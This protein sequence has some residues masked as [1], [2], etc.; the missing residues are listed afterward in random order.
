VAGG[1]AREARIAS[2][3]TK[4]SSR[5][6]AAAAGR[7]GLRV[8]LCATKSLAAGLGAPQQ[9]AAAGACVRIREANIKDDA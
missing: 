2:A 4:T 7:K 3:A 8:G 6:V 5:R 1:G 9:S